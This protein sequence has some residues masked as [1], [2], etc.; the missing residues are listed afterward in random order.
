MLGI[1]HRCGQEV[2]FSIPA[3][4]VVAIARRLDESTQALGLAQ[5][6]EGEG[7]LAELDEAPAEVLVDRLRAELAPTG[8]AVIDSDPDASV[9]PTCGALVRW[10]AILADYAHRSAGGAA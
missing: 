10:L 3:E 6:M 5:W 9:C 4:L 7:L 8:M 1:R 2:Q